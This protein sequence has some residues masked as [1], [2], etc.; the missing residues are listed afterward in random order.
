MKDEL[1]GGFLVRRTHVRHF[2]A[3]LRAG[4]VRPD[5]WYPNF[6]YRYSYDIAHVLGLRV[7]GFYADAGKVKVKPWLVVVNILVILSPIGGGVLATQ[8][9]H[10]TRG[11]TLTS[12]GWIAYFSMLAVVVQ[13]CSIGGVHVFHGL[14][15]SLEQCLTRKGMDRYERWASIAT[16]TL[17]Q[18]AWAMLW[19]SLGC[20]AL[21]VVTLEPS[22]AAAL[23]ITWASYLSVGVSVFYL[24]GGTWWIFAGSVLS[25]RL[26]GEGCMRLFAYA[27]AM[28]PGIELLVRCYRLAFIGACIGVILCL[29]PILTWTRALP[30]SAGAVVAAFSLVALSFL[31]LVMVAVIPD[32]MLS[33][34]I[35][36]ERHDLLVAI[37]SLLPQRPSSVDGVDPREGYLLS[38]MQTL[39]AAPR[40]TINESVIVTIV[41][42]LLSSTLP[43]VLSKYLSL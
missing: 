16:A 12:V 30:A 37:N 41:T 2:A 19:S 1:G 11:Q 7:F 22:I 27:P 13:V 38:W 9:G 33:K 40:G 25:A 17:P 14:T 34:A 18:L 26:A 15:P 42:A 28:T 5:E 4:C 6:Y 8:L 3:R 43:L 29:T 35:L 24:S 31:A 23:H 39:V 10:A 20:L 32:W 36:R 21:Y